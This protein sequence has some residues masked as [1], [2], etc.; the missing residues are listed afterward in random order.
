MRAQ[1]I[2][3]ALALCLAP[4]AA[5]AMTVAQFLALADAARARGVAAMLS[6]EAD[7]LKREMRAIWRGYAADLAVAR[8]EGRA[9]H[10][11]PPPRSDPRLTAANLLA[12]LERIPR[13]QRGMPM[14][15]AFYRIMKRRFPCRA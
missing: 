6:P 3:A 13:T 7:V 1:M 12:E 8:R 5:D 10:S 14:K 11:C 2:A 4:A 15:S 9:P